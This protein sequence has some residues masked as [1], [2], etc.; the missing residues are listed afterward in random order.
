[1]GG[2]FDALGEGR[3]GGGGGAGGAGGAGGVAA[4]GHVFEK[5]RIW[6]MRAMKIDCDRRGSSGGSISAASCSCVE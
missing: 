1:M 4:E 5:V 2:G 3:G 6:L